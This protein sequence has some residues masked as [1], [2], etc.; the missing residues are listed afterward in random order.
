MLRFT[1]EKRLFLLGMQVI[2]LA[3]SSEL[4]PST[5]MIS[6]SE[7]ASCGCIEKTSVQAVLKRLKLQYQQLK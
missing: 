7:L 4:S 3:S 6:E 2:L 5:S 1:C